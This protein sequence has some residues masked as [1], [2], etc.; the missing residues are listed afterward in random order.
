MMGIKK[1]H[2]PKETIGRLGTCGL[3]IFIVKFHNGESSGQ[4]YQGK[5]LLLCSQFTSNFLKLPEGHCY[6]SSILEIDAVHVYE[7]SS[8]FMEIP[9]LLV[10]QIS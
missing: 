8:T 4:K 7:H 5:N 2:T 1:S 6:S 10:L 3:L 9:Y